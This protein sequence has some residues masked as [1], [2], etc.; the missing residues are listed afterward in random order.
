METAK[1][2]PLGW[3]GMHNQLLIINHDQSV[4][5]ELADLITGK[6]FYARFM[7]G[8]FASYVWWEVESR[9]WNAEVWV[10][11]EYQTSYSCDS[12]QNIIKEVNG[13]YLKGP[14]PFHRNSATDQ[15]NHEPE[16]LMMGWVI[17]G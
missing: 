10:N 16:N 2:I 7:G 1:R 4:N 9:N 5:E 17:K 3:V 8:D 15:M 11:K 13:K 14:L 12:L 6:P